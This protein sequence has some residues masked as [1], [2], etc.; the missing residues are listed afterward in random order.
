M[1]PLH[2]MLAP[3]YFSNNTGEKNIHDGGLRHAD[4]KDKLTIRTLPGDV[5][6]L[7]SRLEVMVSYVRQ[8]G[9]QCSSKDDPGNPSILQ[10][11]RDV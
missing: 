7:T 8:T 5:L 3:K 1:L 9:D 2:V 11:Q 4:Y 10:R 6:V